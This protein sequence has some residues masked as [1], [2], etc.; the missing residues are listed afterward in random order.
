MPIGFARTQRVGPQVRQRVLGRVIAT[1]EGC[2]QRGATNQAW[3]TITALFDA[4]PLNTQMSSIRGMSTRQR[5][6]S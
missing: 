6:W 2:I 1:P 4:A 3:Q 5:M